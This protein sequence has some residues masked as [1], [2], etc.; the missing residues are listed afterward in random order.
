MAAPNYTLSQRFALVDYDAL[1]GKQQEIYNFQKATGLLCRTM[2]ESV[3]GRST[4][5]D[6]WKPIA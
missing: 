1:N 5:D 6:R 3:L 2:N 4:I